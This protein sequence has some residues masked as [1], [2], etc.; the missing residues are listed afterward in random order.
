MT[1]PSPLHTRRCVDGAVVRL[2]LAG[3]V[4]GPAAGQLLALVLAT[5]VVERADDLVIDLDA[6]GFLDPTG[7]WALLY[8]YGA[9]VEYG[10]VYRVLNAHGQPHRAL[11][12][13]GMLDVLRD[14]QDT[15][16]A[17][18]ALAL[19]PRPRSRPGGNT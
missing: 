15:G 13:T 2:H 4:R 17:L 10:T 7:V 14:S 8:G 3:E 16:A 1:V 12:A 5:V 19:L 9:A 11:R 6:V 18:V